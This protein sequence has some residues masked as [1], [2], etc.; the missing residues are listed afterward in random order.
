MEKRKIVESIDEEAKLK[1][2]EFAGRY[3]L[4]SDV[5]KDKLTT[6]QIHDSCMALQ[7]V[8]RNFPTAS[9]DGWIPA[10]I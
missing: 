10:S 8:E 2:L 5:G 3:V 1:S 4:V 7:K 9:K 6:E